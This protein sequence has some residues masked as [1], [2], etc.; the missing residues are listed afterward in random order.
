MSSDIDSE[1]NMALIQ[2]PQKKQSQMTQLEFKMTTSLYSNEQNHA[3]K[4]DVWF[5]RSE[6]HQ[7]QLPKILNSEVESDH[8]SI[9]LIA[10]LKTFLTVVNN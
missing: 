4:G 3:S 7:K 6:H 9:F 2:T 10:S 1:K 5:S 8:L